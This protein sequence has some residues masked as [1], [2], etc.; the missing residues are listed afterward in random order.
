MMDVLVAENL[1][2]SI[3]TLTATQAFLNKNGYTLS[4]SRFAQAAQIFADMEY[5]SEV[6][7]ELFF[8]THPEPDKSLLNEI[9]NGDGRSR[10]Q[11]A[12]KQYQEKRAFFADTLENLSLSELRTLLAALRIKV[13]GRYKESTLRQI[14]LLNCASLD[15]DYFKKLIH[16]PAELE[17]F[18]TVRPKWITVKD[19]DTIEAEIPDLGV[20]SIRLMGID[21]PEASPNQK[22]LKDF[23]RIGYEWTEE[24]RETLVQIGAESTDYLAGLVHKKPL[25]LQMKAYEGAYAK[26]KYGRYLAYLFTGDEDL[27]YTMLESGFATVW[28]RLIKYHV[29]SHPRIEEYIAACNQASN[30]KEGLWA[31]GMNMMCPQFQKKKR[32]SLASCMECCHVATQTDE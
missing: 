31:E 29:F 20:V 4:C 21:A 18:I 3:G 27:C 15:E 8:R 5:G 24:D 17:S 32:R 14:A 26:D 10:A 12:F 23:K 22:I 1:L 16:G 25:S 11:K 28:P 6:L 13:D 19:G 7:Y 2:R 30:T 9:F